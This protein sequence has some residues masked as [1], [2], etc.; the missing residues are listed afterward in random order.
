MAARRRIAVPAFAK[1]NLMLRVVGRRE[2][3]YHDLQTVFQS[4]ALH[5]T[6][7]LGQTGGALRLECDDPACPTDHTNLA[8][9]AAA[10]LWTACGRRGDPRGLVIHLAKRIPLEAGLGGGSSDA[11]ATLVGLARLWRVDEQRVHEVAVSLGADVPYFLEGGTTLGLGRGDLLFP[12]VDVAP[13]W[14]TLV[15]PSFGVSTREA[16]GWWDR[17]H[18]AR[19]KGSKRQTRLAP[20]K[21]PTR[22]DA[23]PAVMNDLQPPVATHHPSITRIADRLRRLGAC[24]A[25][26]SGSGSA[27]FGLF[28]RRS[29]AERAASDVFT[30]RQLLAGS[31][32]CVGRVLITRTIGRSRYARLVGIRAHRI[33]LPFARRGVGHS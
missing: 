26:M 17:A 6:V 27:V 31:G 23:A 9:T 30:N 5:D 10:R 28:E 14:V 13:F 16:Y 12:L 3:G 22:H 7:T 2:D 19:A 1:I 8:W 20:H 24:H 11:A 4:I 25:A 18:A 29:A 32:G 21:S 33:D 15:F